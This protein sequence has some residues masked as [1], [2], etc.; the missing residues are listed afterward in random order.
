MLSSQLPNNRPISPCNS[1]LS[2]LDF[3]VRVRTAHLLY[4]FLLAGLSGAFVPEARAQLVSK[5]DMTIKGDTCV[6]G[7]SRCPNISEASGSHVYGVQLRDDISGVRYVTPTANSGGVRISPTRLTFT[8]ENDRDFQYVTVTAVDDKVIT[9]TRNI[10]LAFTSVRRI[11]GRPVRQVYWT[12]I[13]VVENDATVSV[14]PKTL[15]IDTRW[16]P[17]ATR[18]E[19]F[20][21]GLDNQPAGVVQ[22]RITGGNPDLIVSEGAHFS[23]RPHRFIPALWNELQTGFVTARQNTSGRT[24]LHLTFSGGGYER[25]KAEVRVKYGPGVSIPDPNLRAGLESQLGKSVGEAILRSE[26]EELTS[27]DLRN[28]TLNDLTGLEYATNLTDLSLPRTSVGSAANLSVLSRLTRLTRLNLNSTGISD[29]SPLSSLT[30]LERLELVD[31]PI[32][33]V[34]LLSIKDLTSLNALFLRNTMITDIEPLVSGTAL[35]S[36]DRVDLRENTLNAAI[37]DTQIPA[38]RARGVTVYADTDPRPTITV[39]P[40]TLTIDSSTRLGSYTIVLDKQPASNLSIS[41]TSEGDVSIAPRLIYFN[42]SNWNRPQTVNVQVIPRSR[43]GRATITHSYGGMTL[44]QRVRVNYG[45]PVSIP[46]PTLRTALERELNKSAGDL[47]LR[48]ELAELAELNIRNQANFTNLTGLEHA[49]GLT[50]LLLPRN[51]LT[52]IS[53]LSGLTTLT[54]LDLGGNNI[55]DLAPLSGL[56]ALQKLTLGYNAITDVSP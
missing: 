27:L 32:T 38:L 17:P 42:R 55:S 56:T 5:G 50:K 9:G 46:D 48:S 12:E 37:Y 3:L 47:I 7:R 23:P 53:T 44:T 2:V 52:D 54:E 1:Y 20:K 26:L 40:A 31:N 35:G 25:V 43:T 11:R 28:R 41:A 15:T 4:A 29:L 34:S 24:T 21:Y 13:N 14:S 6:L 49:T 10:R 51:G 33:T 18:R 19:S 39:S 45:A 30:A 36:G 16:S 8:P 22:T